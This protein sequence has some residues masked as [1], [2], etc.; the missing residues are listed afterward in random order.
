MGVNDDEFLAKLFAAF[1]LEADE[2]IRAIAKGLVELEQTPDGGDSAEI[3][4]TMYRDSHSLKGAARAVNMDAVESLCQAVESVFSALKR[5]RISLSREMFDTLHIAVDAMRDLIEGSGD[6][7]L[8]S[9]VDRL[10]CIETGSALTAPQPHQHSA[11]ARQPSISRLEEAK[12]ERQEAEEAVPVP[13]ATVGGDIRTL[14]NSPLNPRKERPL[15]V[16]TVRVA[17]Q[18]LDPLLRQAGEMV[19]VK[20]T[21]Q[22]RVA[23]L[24]NIIT[25]FD[26]WK[27]K[28]VTLSTQGR[29]STNMLA[30]KGKVAQADKTDG[31]LA[32]LMDFLEWNQA[33]MQSLETKLRAVARAAEN[34][35]RLHGGMVDDL[36]EDMMNVLMLPCSSLLEMFPKLV[37][38]LSRDAG[39][40]VNL[41]MSGEDLEIDRRILEEIKE[42]LIHLVRNS[43]DHGIERPEDRKKVGKPSHGVIT[44]AIAQVSG[45]QV[46]VVVSDDGTGIDVEKVREAALKRGVV[47][48]REDYDLDGQGALSLVFRSEVSTSSIITNISGRGLG[49]A[50]VREKV[51][52]LAGSISV[53]T[54]PRVGA[55]F[56]ILLPVTLSTFR[57]IFVSVH[58]HLLVIPTANVERVARIRK[59]VVRRVANRE[60]IE[61]NGSPVP[62]VKLGDAL[63]IPKPPQKNDSAEFLSVLVLRSGQVLIAFSVDEILQEQEV[64]LKG[65]G[66]QLSR[67]R[68]ISG[69]T[70]LGSG[71]L[72]PILHVPDLIKSAMK[73][74]RVG[75]SSAVLTEQS[76]NGSKSVLVVEDSIT[77]RML[78][79]NILESSGYLV[80]TA[81]DGVDAWNA[82]N[83]ESFDVVVS[84]VEMP[85]MDGFTLTANIRGDQKLF[86][87]PVVLVTTLGSREDRERGVEVGA[88][89]Y[90]V[91]G[92]FDHNN[93]LE[94][95]DRLV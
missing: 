20:L 94:T 43:I 64:L 29:A 36:L 55:S 11:R 35:A 5:K 33:C 60:T 79:K 1:E 12:P 70:V 15:H 17:V 18:K 48:E 34:D 87:L 71:K 39:K 26:Q 9:L 81:V 14:E 50:I 86:T 7:E 85:R 92:T 10:S 74:T 62:I 45:N 82:L 68:N 16:E 67:V 75:L 13:V 24:D 54:T 53:A 93:L 40:E 19:S 61:I 30:W 88:N 2:H 56:R 4:E 44:I 66:K 84:D 95:V 46:E 8:P 90:I 23:E 76:E 27:K 57:G 91:K 89:A 49:L 72:A 83:A 32:R 80:K 38:D 25:I 3:I 41:E 37:R 77:S 69:A 52:N 6:A 28:W 42:P 59:E 22:Q 51:E 65:L 73:A 47:S 63:E 21:T 58:D 78:L 31:Q